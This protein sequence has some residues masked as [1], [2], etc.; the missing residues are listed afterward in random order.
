M[1]RVRWFSYGAMTCV[2][3]C[4]LGQVLAQYIFDRSVIYPH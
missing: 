3:A 2:A 1:S 4:T